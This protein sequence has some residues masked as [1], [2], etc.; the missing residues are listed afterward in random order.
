M[1]FICVNS[2][3]ESK[4]SFL[5]ARVCPETIYH[6]CDI[7]GKDDIRGNTEIFFK[8]MDNLGLVMYASETVAEIDALLK[9]AGVS[10][11]SAPTPE[12]IAR[13]KEYTESEW[14]AYLLFLRAPNK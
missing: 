11:I 7:S 10:I 12:E 2:W 4:K 13:K 9:E 6:Y 1:I 3:C 14:E 8:R 5:T